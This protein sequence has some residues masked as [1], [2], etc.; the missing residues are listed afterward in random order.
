MIEP[1]DPPERIPETNQVKAGTERQGQEQ[2]P[3]LSQL[4]GVAHDFNNLLSVISGYADL[5]RVKLAKTGPVPEE[6]EEIEKAASEAAALARRL[7]NMPAKP[8]TDASP[9]NQDALDASEVE[10]HL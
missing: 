9:G 5:L 7:F 1:Q 10:K 4:A 2:N 3:G 8:Q 6:L